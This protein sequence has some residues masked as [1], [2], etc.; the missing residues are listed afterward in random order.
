MAAAVQSTSYLYSLGICML[1]LKLPARPLIYERDLHLHGRLGSPSFVSLFLTFDIPKSTFA[2]DFELV[3]CLILVF[4][5]SF[6]ISYYYLAIVV[7]QSRLPRHDISHLASSYITIPSWS[8]ALAVFTSFTVTPS[9]IRSI[10]SIAPSLLP[11]LQFAALVDCSL[12][13]APSICNISR[14]ILQALSSLSS[15]RQSSSSDLTPTSSRHLLSSL[16]HFFSFS[17]LIT[18]R[19]RASFICPARPLLL[20]HLLNTRSK[21]PL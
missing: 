14:V 17:L 4:Y 7:L 8:Y 2:V 1:M 20:H 5:I 13:L 11:F 21:S 19:V 6:F 12:P 10:Q 3:C 16:L 15:H 9:S 18:R